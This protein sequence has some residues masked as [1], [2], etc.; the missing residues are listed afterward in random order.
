[1]VIT[2]PSADQTIAADNLL[3]ASG[4]TT[5]SLG[6]ATAPWNAELR[7]QNGV[8]FA[9]A[10][11]G[12]DIFAKANAAAATLTGPGL[13]VIPP[14]KYIGV[15]TTLNCLSDVEFSCAGVSVGYT[16]TGSAIKC[17]S[18]ARA[19]VRGPLH[20]T[21]N[22]TAGTFAIYLGNPNA[23][24]GLTTECTFEDITIGDAPGV[25]ASNGFNIG[26]MVDGNLNSGT[27]YNHF[28]RVSSNG[29]ASHG[30]LLKPTLASRANSNRYDACTATQ[31]GG[32]GFQVDGS[33]LNTWTGIDCE[34]NGSYNVNLAA[35]TATNSNSFFGGDYENSTLGDVNFGGANVNQTVFL[36][37]SFVS[38]IPLVGD[39][40]LGNN[41]YFLPSTSP[42][43]MWLVN[44]TTMDL[45]VGSASGTSHPSLRVRD[46]ENSNTNLLAV[47]RSGVGAGKVYAGS[48][49]YPLTIGGT[50]SSYNGLATVGNG[51]GAEVATVDLT[52]QTAAISAATLFAVVNA[53]QYRVSWNSKVT[54][55]AGTSSTL[56]PLTI[57]YTDPDGTVVVVICTAG[58]VGG[59]AGTTGTG[60]NT[61]TALFG[62]PALLN[63]KA[64]TNI[65]Y[66]MGYASNAANAMAYNLHI[67]LELL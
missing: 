6:T 19:K 30:W 41:N 24:I 57:T 22:K 17:Q 14:G 36:G 60:N 61:S 29:N 49:Q 1:M 44:G 54:T 67:R 38:T 10:F 34:D 5:Q 16:G 27:Y 12:T 8:L 3:P 56:G 45:P 2:N 15:T 43:Q 42:G 7:A 66:A 31:N 13:V 64:G 33:S 62:F 51:I 63:C 25:G 65:Q 59:G 28:R 50:I 32:D 53:G 18:V 37:G 46:T 39:P 55:A 26:V 20:L 52:S 47:A 58:G 35:T 9:D 4:N 40:S 21:S 48:A 11:T 23:G